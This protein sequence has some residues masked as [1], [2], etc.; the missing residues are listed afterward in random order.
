[1]FTSGNLWYTSRIFHYKGGKYMATKKAA[2]TAKKSTVKKS[3]A[4][5]QTKVTTVKAV[6][7]QPTERAAAVSN[8]SA[9]FSF[10]RSPLVVALLA[11]FVGTFMF[12]SA[13]VAGQGQPILV[14]F[15]L[16][17]VVLAVGALS[18]AHVNPAITLGAWV[19][20]RITGIKALGYVVAQVL[21]AML[22]LVVLQAF[23]D[24]APKAEAADMFSSGGATELFKAAALPEG[25]EW[26]V[27]FAELL[28]ATIL[29]FAVANALS[30]VRERTA[31][32]LTVG[33]GIFVALMV[34]GSAA[35]YIGATAILNP[36]VAISLQAINFSNVWPLGVY[37]LGAGLGGVVGFI[38]YDLMR[39]A[40]KEA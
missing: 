28:G 39:S 1:M 37:V 16:A 31:A 11:E 8:R 34:A 5:K 24:G 23:V 7:S 15:A 4:A 17:G 27:F 20:R 35:A 40:K 21:G 3:N 29:G 13:V 25:K 36:A 6:E 26:Y 18:G 19:T 10:S 32:A 9:R 14:L 2:S 33:L 30:E 12:A 22:A 38:L